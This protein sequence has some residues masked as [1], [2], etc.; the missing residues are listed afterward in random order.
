MN[1]QKITLW[2]REEYSYPLAFGFLPNLTAY[3][4]DDS[5]SAGHTPQKRPCMIVVPG[6]GY[7]VVSPTEAE[8]VAKVFYKM[9][10][11]A[12]VLTYTTNILIKEPLLDQPMKD[13]SRAVRY[14]RKHADALLVNP[15]Q[16]AVCG[17][18]AGGHLCAS[19]CVH[20]ADIVDGNTA[21]QGISNRP[22]AA[23]LS[24]PVITSGVYAHKGSFCALLGGYRDP[25]TG[26]EI[27]SASAQ[28]QHYMSLEKHVTADTP[29]CFLWQTAT[30]EL[31]PV[32]N[33]YLFAQALKAHHI[34]YAHHVFSQGKHGLSLANDTW[35]NHE[36]G[37]PY[38]LEQI[39]RL[40]D[41][42]RAGQVDVPESE[43]ARLTEQFYPDE[44]KGQTMYSGQEPNEEAAVWP[45]L[46]NSWL[47]QVL[48]LF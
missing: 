19:V 20:Y 7:C 6:G 35:A 13:L 46:A 37:D 11:Q 22:D 32:E 28:A 25:Q 18:S 5:T 34:P 8:I 44:S 38:S 40:I 29:P 10:Y 15:D 1:Q 39:Y 43:T 24:Y 21:Y 47:K 9:G 14:I 31:V 2:N 45:V 23:I 16:I 27:C 33:S 41:A 36:Y 48:K 30:D 26:E 12:F 4:H 17:F 3:L 42:M